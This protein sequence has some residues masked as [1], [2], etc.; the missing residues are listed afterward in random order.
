MCFHIE[1]QRQPPKIFCKKQFS[2]LDK[3]FHNIRKGVNILLK[4]QAITLQ[5][6]W[7]RKPFQLFLDNFDKLQRTPPSGYFFN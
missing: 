6:Y 7:K 4:L 2:Q 5:F 1:L 3:I